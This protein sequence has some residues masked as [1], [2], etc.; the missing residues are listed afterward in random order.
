MAQFVRI[1]LRRGVSSSKHY[2]IAAVR[3]VSSA[4]VAYDRMVGNTIGDR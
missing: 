3:G 1:E 2:S 4:T